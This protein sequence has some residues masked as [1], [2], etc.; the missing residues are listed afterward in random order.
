MRNTKP[1]TT[2]CNRFTLCACVLCSRILV[3]IPVH[4]WIDPLNGARRHSGTSIYLFDLRQNE[5]DATYFLDWT[6]QPG[7]ILYSLAYKQGFA[8]KKM[9]RMFMGNEVKVPVDYSL[10]AFCEVMFLEPK[11]SIYLFTDDQLPEADARI[12]QRRGGLPPDTTHRDCKSLSICSQP[13]DPFMLTLG[14]SESERKEGRSGLHLY[15]RNI[16]I[17]PYD[18]TVSVNTFGKS[19]G[20]NADGLIGACDL[21]LLKPNPQKE[22]FLSSDIHAERYQVVMVELDTALGIFQGRIFDEQNTVRAIREGEEAVTSVQCGICFSWRVCPN[23]QSEPKGSWTCNMWGLTCNDLRKED[24]SVQSRQDDVQ[25]SVHGEMVA[26]AMVISGATSLPL[27]S[28]HSRITVGHCFWCFHP[29]P[30]PGR[31]A[32]FL[33]KVTKLI[34]GNQ[35]NQI[36]CKKPK[37]NHQKA[38][39]EKEAREPSR[40]FRAQMYELNQKP[41]NSPEQRGQNKWKSGITYQF[42]LDAGKIIRTTTT[43]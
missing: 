42:D 30:G 37:G 38:P 4:P 3:G 24:E 18:Q 31:Y 19:F 25:Y 12:Q 1:S 26:S 14:Y 34:M 13:E 10:R 21:F 41:K 28:D 29:L 15:W 6:S 35:H 11:M 16:L 36:D 27:K 9:F 22:E 33:Y 2:H 32:P 8:R 7:D 39:N 17:S 5:N 20:K 23:S 40:K 43:A